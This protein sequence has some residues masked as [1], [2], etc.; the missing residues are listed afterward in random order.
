MFPLSP[1]LNFPNDMKKLTLICF[2]AI[3]LFHAHAQA[4]VEINFDFFYDSLSSLG[5]WSKVGG[6][7]YVWHP[8]DVDAD[9]SPYSDGYWSYTDA[10]WTWV[11]Y[12]DW[13]GIT[14]HYGRWA[15]I[16]DFGWCWVPGY[17]WGPAWVSWRKN[18]DHVGWAPLPPEAHFHRETGFGVWVDTSFDIGPGSFHF[19]HVRDFGAPVLRNVFVAREENVT[20]IS[21]TVNITNI[22]YRRD[23]GYAFNGG[24]DYDWIAPRC[25]R[26]VPALKLV[27]NTT[28]IYVNGNKGNVFINAAK[29]NQLIVAAPPVSTAAGYSVPT[30]QLVVAKTIAAPVIKH[31]WAGLDKDGQRDRLLVKMREQD[32]GLTAAN[33]PARIVKAEQLA[34]VPKKA[35]PNAKMPTASL[36]IPVARTPIAASV[37]PTTGAPAGEIVKPVQVPVKENHKPTDIVQPPVA[38]PPGAVVKQ[39]KADEPAKVQPVATEPSAEKPTAV[40]AE[41]AHVPNGLRVKPTATDRNGDGK[42][43]RALPVARPENPEPKVVEQPVVQPKAELINKAHLHSDALAAKTEKAAAAKAA[44]DQ[45]AAQ[46]A[47][48]AQAAK[49]Q[50]DDAKAA[51]A[52]AAARD[53]AATTERTNALHQQQAAQQ[54]RTNEA[55]VEKRRQATE[56]NQADDANRA[57][58]DAAKRENV[59]RAA[60]AHQQAADASRQRAADAQRQSAANEQRQQAADASR[61]RAADAQRQSAANEQRQ[62]AADAGRQRAADANRE[63]AADAQRQNA[64][65]AANEQ[66]QQSIN[67]ARQHAADAQQRAAESARH[68]APQQAQRPPQQQAQPQSQPQSQPGQNSEDPRIKKKKSSEQ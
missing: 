64:A 14:Y 54:Q 23:N 67:A 62:Q 8:S 49:Q 21:N 45:R 33:A 63:R 42:P 58:Q 41:P 16:E 60:A 36:K 1:R 18:E 24:I 32:R 66:R 39:H 5:E 43:D 48:A 4:R 51:R 20:Y 68:Q 25:E 9:W 40:V 17:E 47:Q 57:A 15:E 59:Q 26:P 7:G 6:Y 27:Q 2:S 55:A 13:G 38:L 56:A 50:K 30:R 10:G 65:N 31:G 28:N 46:A 22:S 29:G 53:N 11:S 12:E 34:V 19:C 52:E 35:D 37:Q 3:T 44:A 61:Q